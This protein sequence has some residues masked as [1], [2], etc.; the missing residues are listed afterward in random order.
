MVAPTA[1]SHQKDTDLTAL[2]RKLHPDEC[3]HDQ[4]ILLDSI[5]TFE[6]CVNKFHVE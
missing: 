5:S 6:G 2:I 1:L 3:H 4:A